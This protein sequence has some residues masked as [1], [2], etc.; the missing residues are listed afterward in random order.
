[1]S[2]DDA[3]K[4]ARIMGL[5]FGNNNPT[6][7]SMFTNPFKSIND[8]GCDCPACRA[9]RGDE[10]KLE[11]YNEEMIP[12]IEDYLL[13]MKNLLCN[14]GY[15]LVD[16]T[17]LK[18]MKN[19]VVLDIINTKL[20]EKGI[21]GFSDASELQTNL[22]ALVEFDEKLKVIVGDLTF[23]LAYIKRFLEMS[24]IANYSYKTA[25]LITRVIA[26]NIDSTKEVISEE[27][28]DTKLGQLIE[29]YQYYS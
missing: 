23:K 22:L 4:L 25:Q 17:E 27:I 15:L 16:L 13:Y 26:T 20:K 11:Q 9:A 1:M 19:D 12:Q 2:G 8:D 7:K 10:S 24:N 3:K 14:L 5:L 28:F 6:N 29:D 18:E 21:P